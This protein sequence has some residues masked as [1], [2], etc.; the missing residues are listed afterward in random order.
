MILIT[1]NMRI[2]KALS[3]NYYNRGR[4]QAAQMTNFRRF[5]IMLSKGWGGMPHSVIGNNILY[6]EWNIQFG[7]GG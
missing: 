6:I 2:C 4:R 7:V 1:L 3:I 5:T